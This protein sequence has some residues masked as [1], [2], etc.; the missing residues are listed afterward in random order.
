MFTVSLFSELASNRCLG[1][2]C[3]VAYIV[4]AHPRCRRRR[5]CGGR[6]DEFS[7]A[8]LQVWHGVVGWVDRAPEIHI[9]HICVHVKNVTHLS[10]IVHRTYLVYHHFVE[11]G[12]VGDFVEEAAGP[13]PGIGN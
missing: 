2:Y 7:F 10:L 12:Y 11:P 13:D 4:Q 9:L 8:G 1:M 5:G 3:F 6:H